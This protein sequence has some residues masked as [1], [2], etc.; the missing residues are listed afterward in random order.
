MQ[1]LIIAAVNSFLDLEEGQQKEIKGRIFVGK[2][3]N[4]TCEE[5]FEVLD[6][7][8]FARIEYEPQFYFVFGGLATHANLRISKSSVR[9]F[10]E[11]HI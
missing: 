7:A 3:Q 11:V 8:S 5:C 10:F 1:N 2:K 9:N 4:G 6:L